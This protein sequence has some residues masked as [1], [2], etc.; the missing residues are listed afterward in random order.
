MHLM[1]DIEREQAWQDPPTML[2]AAG[3]ALVRA[4]RGAG[5]A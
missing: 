4:L 2:A 1:I 5:L 3:F